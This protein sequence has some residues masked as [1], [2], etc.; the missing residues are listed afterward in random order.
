MPKKNYEIKLSEAEIETLQKITHKGSRN[1][2]KTILH[3]NIL[4]KTNES[5]RSVREIAEIFE[6]SP[7]TVNK[8]ILP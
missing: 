3:A 2:A 4:L 6:V 8:V 7:N 5:K 1:T